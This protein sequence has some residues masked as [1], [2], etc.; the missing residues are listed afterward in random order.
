VLRNKDLNEQLVI[1]HNNRL[2]KCQDEDD[3]SDNELEDE[4]NLENT[5][6]RADA[7]RH[8]NTFGRAATA[9]KRIMCKKY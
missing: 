6:V 3:I 2:K 1:Q 8:A 4:S 5:V 7:G 9:V